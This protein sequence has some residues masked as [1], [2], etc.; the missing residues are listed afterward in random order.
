MPRDLE[1]LVSALVGAA[2]AGQSMPTGPEQRVLGAKL[3][4]ALFEYPDLPGHGQAA[5]DRPSPVGAGEGDGA[6]DQDQGLVHRWN[7][8]RVA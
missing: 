2:L 3:L 4:Q 7:P 6:C 8:D 5:V 1:A